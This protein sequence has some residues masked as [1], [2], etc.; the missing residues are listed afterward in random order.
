MT[1]HLSIFFMGG[2][3]LELSADSFMVD[4]MNRVLA[5]QSG[6]DNYVFPLENMKYWKTTKNGVV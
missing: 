1:L 4:H 3:A 2:T 5:V 6:A